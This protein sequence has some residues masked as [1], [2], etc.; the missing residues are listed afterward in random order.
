M[1]VDWLSVLR[2]CCSIVPQSKP[3]ALSGRRT[4]HQCNAIAE[5]ICQSVANLV[6][7]QCNPRTNQQIQCRLQPLKGST[8]QDH[9]ARK[10]NV[11]SIGRSNRVHPQ[12]NMSSK[13][14]K[15][16]IPTDYDHLLSDSMGHEP[17][18]EDGGELD[19]KSDIWLNPKSS[20]LISF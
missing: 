19:P 14:V 20:T 9:S 5:P 4:I 1:V 18:K 8:P 16:H 3:M 12:K 17:V 6:L 10:E 15:P 11:Q 7:I 2:Q 13:T